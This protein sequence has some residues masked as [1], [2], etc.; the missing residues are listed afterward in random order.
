M[1]EHEGE[2]GFVF[3]DK[4]KIDPETGEVR[5]AAEE[6]VDIAAPSEG[7]AAN[8]DAAASDSEALIGMEIATLREDVQRIQAEYANYR[9]R[10]ER[11]RSVARDNAIADVLTALLPVLDDMQRAREH[12]E[13]TGALKALGE[14]VEAVATRFGLETYG[15]ADEPFDPAVHEALTH[16]TADDAGEHP[17]TVVSGVY[18]VGYRHV[19]RV[20]RPARVGVEDRA[21]G[22]PA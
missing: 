3:K 16:T 17:V 15:A 21:A 22:D 13:F 1:T 4:R 19:G 18:Q 12:N 14:A 20:L 11:D 7:T 2:S 5:N 8:A 9:K 6:G 10:V